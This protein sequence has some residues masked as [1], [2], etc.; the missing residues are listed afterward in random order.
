MAAAA[1]AKEIKKIDTLFPSI[2]SACIANAVS[3]KN[4]K[5]LRRSYNQSTL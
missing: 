1:R 4:G 3:R 5:M 2:L